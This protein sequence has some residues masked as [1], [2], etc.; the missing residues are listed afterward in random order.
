[1]VGVPHRPLLTS[2]P[3]GEGQNLHI[4]P[5]ADGRSDLEVLVWDLGFRVWG[6]GFE[7][8]G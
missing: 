1:M 8:W 2:L 3:T 4:H 5:E 6:L 7:A